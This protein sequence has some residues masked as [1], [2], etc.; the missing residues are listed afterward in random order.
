MRAL[1]H[2]VEKLG[3]RDGARIHIQT[4]V[5]WDGRGKCGEV[6]CHGDTRDTYKEE[7]KTWAAR[8]NWGVEENWDV[9]GAGYMTN[10]VFWPKTLALKTRCRKNGQTNEQH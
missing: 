5:G 8:V 9:E 10:P 4:L 1:Q 7:M 3:L 2:G 6:L